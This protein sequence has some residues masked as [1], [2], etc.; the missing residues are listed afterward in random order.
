MN[1]RR[2]GYEGQRSRWVDEVAADVNLRRDIVE[3][4]LDSFFN[5]FAER[6][7]NEGKATVKGL[8]SIQSSQST[9]LGAEE[10]KLSLRARVSAPVRKLYLRMGR[11]PLLKVTRSN[12]RELAKQTYHKSSDKDSNSFAGF[13]DADDEDI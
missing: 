1:D 4:V 7:L 8:F 11:E 6:V 3:Q 10:G 5:I 9:G 2:P 12:W 13:L